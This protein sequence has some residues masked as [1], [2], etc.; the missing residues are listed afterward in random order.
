VTDAPLGHFTSAHEAFG[1][2]CLC[3]D[4]DALAELLTWRSLWM[5][6]HGSP[7]IDMDRYARPMGDL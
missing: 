4:R 5:R 2:C 7:A 6:D 3:P 1:W